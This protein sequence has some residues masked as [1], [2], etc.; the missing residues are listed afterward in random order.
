MDTLIGE[1]AMFSGGL[2]DKSRAKNDLNK[3][4]LI[5]RDKDK[6]GLT[7]KGREVL[8]RWMGTANLWGA[9]GRLN[10]GNLNLFLQGLNN[11]VG[12]EKSRKFKEIAI[13]ALEQ[14]RQKYYKLDAVQAL[15]VSN[16]PWARLG[17]TLNQVMGEGQWRKTEQQASMLPLVVKVRELT[18]KRL[19][20]ASEAKFGSIQ[21]LVANDVEKLVLAKGYKSIEGEL[22][23]VV[24]K[25]IARSLAEKLGGE[26]KTWV[27]MMIERSEQRDRGWL[28]RLVGRFGGDRLVMRLLVSGL[29]L[30]TAG[31]LV[32]ASVS[33]FASHLTETEVSSSGANRVEATAVPTIQPTRQFFEATPFP[34]ITPIPTELPRR[35]LT[36]AEALDAVFADYI[37]S[38]CL[39]Q[40]PVQTEDGRMV[41]VL[42]YPIN[43]PEEC[44]AKIS[45]AL[46]NLPTLNRP[47]DSWPNRLGKIKLDGSWEVATI[48]TPDA[49]WI[50]GLNLAEAL[51][52]IRA[53]HQVEAMINPFVLAEALPAYKEMAAQLVAEIMAD[54]AAQAVYGKNLP[55]VAEFGAFNMYV[56]D[57]Q[58]AGPFAELQARLGYKINNELAQV[59]FL[60]SPII[61]D[62]MAVVRAGE[63]PDGFLKDFDGAMAEE[64]EQ[65]YHGNTRGN[66]YVLKVKP[67]DLDRLKTVLLNDRLNSIEEQSGV[68]LVVLYSSDAKTQ[69]TY[70]VMDETPEGL[71]V[72]QGHINNNPDTPRKKWNNP[73][74]WAYYKGR[75]LELNSDGILFIPWEVVMQEIVGVQSVYKVP[76]Y[77]DVGSTP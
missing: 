45:Y 29:K 20:N 46:D 66:D 16:S 26:V 2:V 75:G 43:V 40:I 65:T 22:E 51:L 17:E 5:W 53:G 61:E 15:Q 32:W 55:Q 74:D 25:A 70:V 37:K 11:G 77:T 72:V 21:K 28:E 59:G 73:T 19:G 18:G 68:P 10:E 30:A 67:E 47:V 27:Q 69:H 13:E 1:A 4:E 7:F 8:V 36:A 41:S 31:S 39:V 6:S 24:D 35:E 76:V 56:Q 12:D 23:K 9:D 54:P 38:G 33:S 64:V 58:G 3:D 50:H 14:R 63:I 48:Q 49:C 57:I 71:M 52:E 34:T 62:G 60:I 44:R 42:D